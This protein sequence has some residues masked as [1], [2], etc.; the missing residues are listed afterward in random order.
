VHR[1]L[2]LRRMQLQSQGARGYSSHSRYI[3]SVISMTSAATSMHPAA[4]MSS[5][6]HVHFNDLLTNLENRVGPI[7][8]RPCQHVNGYNRRSLYRFKSTPTNEARFTAPSLPWW[9]LIQVLT[10]VDVP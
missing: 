8:L 10:E 5:Q 3:G 1:A 6:G 4:V 7:I 2:A 9:S